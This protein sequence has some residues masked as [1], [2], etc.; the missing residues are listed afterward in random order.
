MSPELVLMLDCIFL[1]KSIY[2]SHIGVL[3]FSIIFFLK[4]LDKI[5]N[6]DQKFQIKLDSLSI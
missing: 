6:T 3:S 4:F 5:E 1:I 2:L